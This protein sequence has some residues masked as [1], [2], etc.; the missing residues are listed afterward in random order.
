M[1]AN[2]PGKLS[3]QEAVDILAYIFAYNRYPS[4]AADLPIQAEFLNLIKIVP[5]KITG[6]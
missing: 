6:H 2:D 3:R 5:P 1:P 4:G